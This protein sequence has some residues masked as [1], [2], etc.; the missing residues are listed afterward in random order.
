MSCP[1]CSYENHTEA[2]ICTRCGELLIVPGATNIIDHDKP[3]GAPKY[4]TVRFVNSL[5]LN[6]IDGESVFVFPKAAIQELMI[7]RSELN[8]ENTPEIDLSAENGKQHGV[9]RRHAVIVQREDALHIRDNGS[10][11]GTFLNGQR[12][13]HDQFRVLRDGDD[14]QLGK[15]V[16]RV[17]FE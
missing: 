3:D 9:S 17:T 7:G 2:K 14:I 6:V 11:N 15:L 4:G 12:L 8:S 1:N 5:K 13:I 16:L 10:S